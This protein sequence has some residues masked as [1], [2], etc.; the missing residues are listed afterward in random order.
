MVPKIPSLTNTIRFA[1][2]LQPSY[3]VSLTNGK[4]LRYGV[5]SGTTDINTLET[6]YTNTQSFII[7]QG[8][9]FGDYAEFNYLT[10]DKNT[11]IGTF[12]DITLNGF[13]I[14]VSIGN[15]FLG[16][17]GNAIVN[18]RI[19]VLEPNVVNVISDDPNITSGK[20]KLNNTYRP[21]TLTILSDV[22]LGGVFYLQRLDTNY[23][24]R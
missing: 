7:N 24:R 19:E 15:N 10:L 9:Y 4:L 2:K 17:T 3:N 23:R 18:I 8:L 14:F 1:R 22:I 5:R 11:P 20:L 21:A 16:I 6:T 13:S 12:I